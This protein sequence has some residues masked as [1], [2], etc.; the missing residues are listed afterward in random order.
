M[1]SFGWLDVDA[2]ERQKMLE[3]VDLFRDSSTVDELGIGPIRDSFSDLLFPGTSTLHTRLRY[4]LFLPWL[5]QKAAKNKRRS[6]SGQAEDFKRSE[7]ALISALKNGGESTGV[8]GERAGSKLKRL[9]SE[10]YHSALKTWGIFTAS[11]PDAYLRQLAAIRQLD[12]GEDDLVA[13]FSGVGFGIDPS[14]PRM[15][16]EWEGNSLGPTTFAL[17]QEEATYLAGKISENVPDSLLTYLINSE[18]PVGDDPPWQEP[19]YSSLPAKYQRQV[20]HA[21][22]FAATHHGAALLYNLMLAQKL[23]NEDATQFYR[24]RIDEWQ[25]FILADQTLDGWDRDDFWR[26]VATKR[27]RLE[28]H[29]ISFAD[30]WYRIAQRCV[31]SGKPIAEDRE[32]RSLI[33]MRELQMKGGRARLKGGT[34]L[35]L[36]QGESGTGVLEYRWRQASSHITDLNSAR[37]VGPQLATQLGSADD[38]V[39]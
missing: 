7:Y 10:M 34:A 32:A 8:I 2:E 14:L 25:G 22:R 39:S 33:E 1:S 30:Q 3:F 35:D 31:R 36:W 19:I 29:T 17:T 20:E 4:V 18:I 16:P 5:L 23:G 28:A 38:S 15:P 11:S 26:T 12:H 21:R 6:P 27:P 9:P 24:E 13:G 37:G